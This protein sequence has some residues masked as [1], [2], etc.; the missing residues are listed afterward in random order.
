MLSHKTA[1]KRT[2]KGK[3]GANG[4]DKVAYLHEIYVVVASKEGQSGTAAESAALLVVG[5]AYTE[6]MTSCSHAK[7]PKSGRESEKRGETD[8]IRLHTFMKY[9]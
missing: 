9:A 7:L 8:R 6:G 5:S 2:G 4:Q 1:Q 3:E